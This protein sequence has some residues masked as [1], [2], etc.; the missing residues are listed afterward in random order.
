M[1]KSELGGSADRSFKSTLLEKANNRHLLN[2]Q[3]SPEHPRLSPTAA[4][5]GRPAGGLRMVLNVN[6]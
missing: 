5:R 6:T 1:D 4:R 3:L 2:G